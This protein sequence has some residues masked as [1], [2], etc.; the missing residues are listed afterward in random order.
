MKRFRYPYATVIIVLLGLTLSINS[1]AQPSN[2]EC[3]AAITLTSNTSCVNTGGTNV[4]ATWNPSTFPGA[5]I[6]CGAT[7]KLDVWYKFVAQ[8]ATETI[9]VSSAPSQIRVQLLSGTCGSFTS[10]YC[11]NTSIAAT[12]LTVGTTYYIRV[13]T[14]NNNTSAFNICVTH[15]PPANDDCS[16]AISLTSNSSCVNTASTLNLATANG[17][18][19][20]GCFAAGTYYD[21]WFSF[22]A[23]T[24]TE[25]VT[26]SSLG[27]NITN[28]QIQ[29]YGG[30][31]GALSNLTACGATTVTKSGLTI[32]TTYYVRVANLGGI[33]PSGSGTVANFNICVTHTAPANDLCSGAISIIQSASCV[34]TAGILVGATYTTIS[35]IGCG[36]ASRNDVWYS[37]TA[38]ST[39]A[40]IA[41]SSAPT[42][43]RLQLFSG[44]CG[45]LTSI[46]C[47]AN[48][49]LTTGLTI[50]NTYYI[51]VYTD[52]DVLNGTFNICVT[53]S[54][55]SNDDCGGAISLTSGNSCSNTAGTLN[56]AT[57]TTGLPIGCESGGAHY[58]VWYKFT[59]VAATETITISSLGANITSSEMQLY[60]GTCG[61]LTS[62]QCAASPTLS[63]TRAGLTVGATYYVRVSN[64]GT[65]PSGSGTVANFNICVTHTGVPNDL[66]SSA[67]ML[68]S[69]YSCSP[70]IGT[71][72]NSTVTSTTHT[73]GGAAPNYDVWYSFVAQS[74]TPTLDI[75]QVGSNFNTTKINV[76]LFTGSCAGSVIC[77]SGLT[78]TLTTV[79]GTTYFI[80]IY[81]TNAIPASNGE[82][83]ICLTDPGPP[84]N[85]ACSA[86]ITLAA[87]STICT[88]T[89]G[90]LAYATASSPSVTSSCSGTPGADVWYSF[91]ASSVFPTITI[92][93]F[94]TSLASGVTKY[95]QLLSG[96]CG[97]FTEISC[98]SG[99]GTSLSLLPV[100]T[101]LTVGATYYVRIYTA[102]VTPTGATWSYDICVTNPGT[103]SIA[104]IDYSKSYV[105][106][107]KL[108]TGGGA[109]P[110]DVLEI[111]ATFVVR[112]GTVDSLAF[113][114][115]LQSNS[116]FT[117][118]SS[119]I[120]TQTNEGKIYQS[121]TDAQDSDA[122]WYKANGA[123]TMVQI[124][125]G[126]GASGSARGRLQNTSLP[127]FYGGTCIIMAT[128][129]VQVN[130]TYDTKINW[131][132]VLLH[133]R[134]VVI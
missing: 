2:N 53:S 96:N 91:V 38:T 79:I 11:G 106:L 68:T 63:I 75:S 62:L 114:D 93:N 73:C 61:A 70:T 102:T 39:N 99:T 104:N 130:A 59:A 118:L 41:L 5:T 43:P 44:T 49:L 25:T 45:T 48:T 107:T 42:N 125:I 132:V 66:C 113:Y 123:D 92:N 13:Y 40:T 15:A 95:I 57:V 112:G 119:T 86:A 30:T 51:R 111:R 47:G 3:S 87:S 67:I 110:G 36:T 101:G 22:V 105:N 100:G 60:S 18:T 58:D 88:P 72:A 56:N 8:A 26:I 82:F 23:A 120:S 115:T 129:R 9:T 71:V 76:E 37:F 27:T 89:T 34:N 65:N 6:G 20:L 19:P 116:G 97:V 126:T 131:G 10:L 31:C 16:G 90:T 24:T 77:L 109:E 74:T 28:P 33:S 50:G 29:I 32:G 78:S 85:D 94:G 103:G 81:G 17:T 14:Q 133:I 46:T 122:G 1:F 21:V 55:V 4:N 83:S 80:R 12:G 117:L 7:N 127:S 69:G 134:M 64:V 84:S 98:M 35:S 121:F 52:P 108:G 124:N 54:T 128:Y